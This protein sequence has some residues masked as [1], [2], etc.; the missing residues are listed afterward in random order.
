MNANDF[1]GSV[2]QDVVVAPGEPWSG[3]IATGETLRI[4]DLE[5]QQ[6]VDFICFNAD[7]LAEA[8]DATVTIRIPRSI[9]LRK[10]MVL[11]SNI[12]RPMLT[13]V[14][15]TVA[16]HDLLC[17]CCS[18]EINQARYGQ[19]GKKSCRDNFLSELGRHGLDPRSLVPNVNFFMDIPLLDSTGRFEIREGPS[20]AGDFVDLQAQMDLLVVLSNCPQ[21]TNAANAGRLSPIRIVVW[22]RD[23]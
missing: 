6:A 14:E 23:Q 11:Y 4:V 12:S 1:P 22:R 18:R 5:G 9:F 8:Y 16:S 13:L 15:D 2:R 20:K 19:P 21:V 3:Q 17:G 10:G 7:D